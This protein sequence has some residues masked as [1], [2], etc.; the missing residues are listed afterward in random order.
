M[1]KIVIVSV[2]ILS[3]IGLSLG[4]TYIGMKFM[5]GHHKGSPAF[6]GAH[7]ALH[8]LK[9]SKEQKE[10]LKP[11]EKE[12]K[13]D[14]DALQ[15]KMA[16]ERIAVCSMMS[17]SEADWKEV[18][19]S[20]EKIGALQ[21]EQQKIVVRHLYKMKDILTDEQRAQFFGSMME[22]IC[23][24]CRAQTGLS[25]AQCLCG[26]CAYHPKKKDHSHHGDTHQ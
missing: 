5:A 12:L 10:K 22:E 3:V 6:A 17:T 20:V 2:V 21:T 7:K 26:H 23:R 16:T 18:D 19:T 15:I 13:E 9:L 14:L 4:L 8:G 11:L 25:D 24:S 1:K